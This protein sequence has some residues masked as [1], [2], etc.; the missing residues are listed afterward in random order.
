VSPA[1]SQD[2]FFKAVDQA[3][4][5]TIWLG[6]ASLG[7]EIIASMIAYVSLMV[8]FFGQIVSKLLSLW[9]CCDYS[10]VKYNLWLLKIL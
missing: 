9:S 4:L 7:V 5:L 3:V 6:I 2:A 8:Y 1:F 10:H